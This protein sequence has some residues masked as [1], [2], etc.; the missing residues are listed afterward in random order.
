MWVAVRGV[1]CV[2]CPCLYGTLLWQQAWRRVREAC[3]KLADDK[4]GMSD[5]VLAQKREAA[6]LAVENGLV[7]PHSQSAHIT[8]QG[9]LNHYTM[10]WTLPSACVTARCT[11]YMRLCE[12]QSRP[13]GHVTSLL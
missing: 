9:D 2:H 7:T 11:G 6:L 4:L 12:W 3:L 8:K 5:V 13:E 1:W 10:V